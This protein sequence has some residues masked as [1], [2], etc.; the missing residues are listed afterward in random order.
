L[1]RYGHLHGSDVE[2][3]GVAINDL[4]TRNCGQSVA[5]VRSSSAWVAG[6]VLRV[7][8]LPIALWRWTQ[9]RRTLA[10]VNHL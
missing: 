9:Q 7:R 6:R 4:L 10:P 2:V 1:D 8:F 3:A 5:T